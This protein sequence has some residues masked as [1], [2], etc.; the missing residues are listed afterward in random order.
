MPASPPDPRLEPLRTEQGD[1]AMVALDQRESLREMFPPLADGAL[2]DDATLVAFKGDATRVLSPFASGMLLDHPLG[3]GGVGRPVVLAE[4]CGLLLAADRLHSVRGAGVTAS[5]LDTDL[6]RDVVQE[7]RADALK[8]LVIWRRDDDGFRSDLAA[9][10]AL[11]EATGL[12]TFVEG[13]V[14][15]PV[16]E[17]WRS[18]RDRFDAIQ[19]AAR[20]LSRGAGVYKAEVPGYS[21]GD[22][23]SVESEAGELSTGIDVPW[24]VLSNGVAQADF[25]GAV[26]ASRAGG[27]AGFLAGRAVWSD[28]VADPD[29]ATALAERSVARLHALKDIVS[30]TPRRTRSGEVTR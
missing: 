17:E 6:T 18:P 27:A 22:L 10:H 28:T 9:F 11:A 7:L 12:P 25:P 2:V 8:Y 19:E 24:V 29:P 30:R 15:P 20:D 3:T 21:P 13:I 14:R 16:G 5:A 1:Y 26:A 4:H 23:D